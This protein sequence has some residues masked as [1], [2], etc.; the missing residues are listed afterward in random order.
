MSELEKIAISWVVTIVA[1][2]AHLILSWVIY[3]ISKKYDNTSQY[4]ESVGGA[5]I[6][7]I[8]LFTLVFLVRIILFD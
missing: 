2:A 8:C 6:L 7:E 5:F 1:I 4:G 3:R